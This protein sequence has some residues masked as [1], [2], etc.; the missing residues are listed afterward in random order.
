MDARSVPARTGGD[1]ESAGDSG[2]PGY[3]GSGIGQGGSCRFEM[4]A[5]CGAKWVKGPATTCDPVFPTGRP[6][7]VDLVA[8]HVS[9]PD[10]MRSA[11]L[12]ARRDLAQPTQSG[13]ARATIPQGRPCGGLILPEI[14]LPG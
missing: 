11:R 1:I 4:T 9:P 3:R 14:S 6:P 10:R 5:A 12:W 13:N 2:D 7:T 8:I